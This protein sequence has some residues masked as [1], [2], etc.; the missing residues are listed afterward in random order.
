MMM[1]AAEEHVGRKGKCPSCQHIMVIPSP[2]STT[3]LN[4]NVTQAPASRAAPPRKHRAPEDDEPV[5]ANPIDEADDGGSRR[6]RRRRDDDEE[7]R[8]RRRPAR[9]LR[10]DED[11]EDRPRGRRRHEDDEDDNR[12]RRRRRPRRSRFR[13]EF[14]DCPNCGARG[15]ATRQSFTW[16]GGLLGPAMINCVSCNHCGT[17]YNGEHGDYNTTRILIYVL[18]S[19]GIGLGFCVLSVLARFANGW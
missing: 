8:P 17:S 18:V 7:D 13:G 4:E 9:A 11:D 5:V 3:P 2:V 16:W 15:D 19:S 1:S 6:G 12:P 14:A 10:D